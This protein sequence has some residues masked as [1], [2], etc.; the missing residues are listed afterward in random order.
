MAINANNP[1]IGFTN[2]FFFFFFERDGPEAASCWS[3]V[4]ERPI[5]SY[6]KFLVP[7]C[8]GVHWILAC[9]DFVNQ[10]LVFCDSMDGRYSHIGKVLNT[11]LRFMGIPAFDLF[12]ESVPQQHNSDDCGVFVMQF[13]RCYLFGY[14]LRSFSQKDIPAAR[15]RIREEL[16]S[17]LYE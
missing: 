7:I 8:C 17:L 9:I 5:N 4:K 14:D 1:N 6:Q 2:S 15:N 12:Y 11:F 10:R 13:V 3:G 16:C